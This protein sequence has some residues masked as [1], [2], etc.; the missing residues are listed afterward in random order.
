M[1]NTLKQIPWSEIIGTV[2]VFLALMLATSGYS[3]VSSLFKKESPKPIDNEVFLPEPDVLSKDTI[4]ENIGKKDSSLVDTSKM[5]TVDLIKE[6]PLV[7]PSYVSNKEKLRKYLET[8][9]QEIVTSG[10]IKE[11]YLYINTNAIDIEKE[12]VYF[13]IVDG[14]DDGGHLIPTESL[15][16]GKSG[17]FLYDLSKLPLIQ[18]PY[19]LSKKADHIDVLGQY[20]N[21]DISY[22]DQRQYFIGAFVSTTIL[23]NQIN[24]MTIRYTCVVGEQCSIKKIAR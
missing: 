16:A 15:S 22:K 21:Q 9:A 8:N 7:T 10:K 1:K 3:F 11:A 19:S 12:S 17:E 5:L 24:Q 13:W 2:I 23:P 4:K 18:L 6:E 20:L 14:K